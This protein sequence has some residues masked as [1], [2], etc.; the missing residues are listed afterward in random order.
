[1]TVLCQL[2]ESQQQSMLANS[3]SS[4]RPSTATHAV[5]GF[6]WNPLTRLRIWR[7]ERGRTTICDGSVVVAEALGRSAPSPSPPP[8]QTLWLSSAVIGSRCPSIISLLA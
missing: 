8:A 7:T 3:L 2:S 5:A 4:I 6:R 1:M